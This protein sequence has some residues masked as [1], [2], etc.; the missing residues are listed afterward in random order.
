MDEK[1]H[2]R[3]HGPGMVSMGSEDLLTTASRHSVVYTLPAPPNITNSSSTSVIP[4][5]LQHDLHP[6]KKQNFTTELPPLVDSTVER[7]PKSLSR[8]NGEVTFLDYLFVDDKLVGATLA[9]MSDMLD[10]YFSD[11]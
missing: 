10:S 8:A 1:N 9:K 3:R 5:A 11:R 7:A 2:Y 6:Q 4:V